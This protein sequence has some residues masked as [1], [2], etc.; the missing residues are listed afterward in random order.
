MKKLRAALYPRVSHHD[1]A[2]FGFSLEAQKKH[3][4]QL[5][6]LKN[7]E[8]VD[9]YE[10]A[11][12]SAKNTNRPE[13][14][15][16]MNDVKKGNIDVVV[17]YKLDRLTR[18]LSDLEWVL[19]EL[20]KYNCNLVSASEDINTS[21]AN[22]RFFI[23]IVILLAELELERTSERIKFVFDEKIRNG[24]AI[25]GSQ[26]LGYTTAPNEN[27][28]KIV[29]K[30]KE[31]EKEIMEIFDYFEKT[32]SLVQTALYTNEKY[33]RIRE[34]NAIKSFIKN[35]LYYGYYKGNHNY[36]TP[37]M[38]KERWDKLNKILTDKNIKFNTP[39]VYIFSSLLKCK[40]CGKKITGTASKRSNKEYMYYHCSW[41]YKNKSC[42]S[43]KKVREEDLENYLIHNL[44]NYIDDYF[45]KLDKKYKDTEIKYRNS[46]ED[47]AKLR[48]EQ[49]RT[50][51]SFNK[52]RI[53]EDKYDKEW[54][55]IEKE[56]AKLK[57]MP[58]KKD[59]SHLKDLKDMSWIEMYREL[60]KENK[61]I[62]W[63]KIID[64]IE[65][66]LEN[67]TEGGEYID[68]HFL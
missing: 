17:C 42:E 55:R 21:T 58:V 43:V 40:C 56:I 52:G 24:G 26:P 45:N 37:Y 51:I 8:I 11:G 39:R 47:I 22:G 54:E 60:T 2:E 5:C 34:G 1:Q 61:Q 6:E 46:S 27:G 53:S 29:V 33:G 41:K 63:R 4:I 65:I 38:T 32:Q 25:T 48:A 66:D 49:E 28:E 62:F 23:K 14:Q 57:E 31:N 15:R 35:P 3:L 36:C 18:S 68:V 7:Y 12:I 16:M 9:I 59:I 13:F 64:I 10:D 50:T 30:D 20:D 19:K 44:N 67:Y